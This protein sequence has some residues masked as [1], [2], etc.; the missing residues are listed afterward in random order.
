MWETKPGVECN[1]KGKVHW[2]TIDHAHFDFISDW[3]IEK[4][5]NDWSDSEIKGKYSFATSH[6]VLTL[7]SM[8]Y[9]LFWKGRKFEIV[10]YCI[11]QVT[12]YVL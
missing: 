4:K 7:N 9:L 6:G 1:L 11:L 5:G 10:V 2:N 12:L 8:P 3:L